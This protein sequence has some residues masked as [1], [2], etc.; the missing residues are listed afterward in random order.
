M[1]LHKMFRSTMTV[2]LM[3]LLSRITGLVRDIA[4]AQFLGSGLVADAFFVAFRIP[5]FFR[6]IF[7][8]GA[9]SAGFVPVYAEYESQYPAPEVRAFLD[10]MLGRL[11]LILLLFTLLGVLGAPWLV[12]IIAPGFVEHPDK[13]AATVEALRFTFPYLFFV[14][15]VAMAGGILNTRG[16]FAVPAITPVFL[17]LFLIGAV[18]WAVP[19]ATHKALTLGIGVF[20][21]GVVQLGFQLPFLAFE[22]RLPFP[23]I[24]TGKGTQAVAADGVGRVFS[25]MLP[26]LFGVSVAQI[27][28]LINTVLASFLVTGSV[29]WLYYSDRLMEFPVGVFGIALA[30]VILPKLSKQVAENAVEEYRQTIDWALRLALLVVCPAAV[31]LVVLAHPLMLT[32]FQYGEFTDEDARMAARSLVAFSPGLIG[33][34]LVKVLAPGFF[35]RKDTKTPVRA[36]VIAMAVNGLCA[37]AL[38]LAVPL[39]H[40]GLAA[41]TSI[42]GLVNAGLLYRYLVRDSG[43]MSGPGMSGFAV[44][45]AAAA[46]VMGV[47][48]WFG[49]PDRQFWVAASVAGRLWQL[50]MWVPAGTVV[51]FVCLYVV[52]LKPHR[53]FQR[54]T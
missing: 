10:L 8:E 41:A 26:A 53:L 27:N 39:G 43:Y 24:M 23:K 22:R 19:F 29:S 17:N 36:G 15:L 16:R 49:V 28:L 54:Q 33:F 18:I 9:F 5:N 40:V 48:L 1:V 45:T 20:V 51:Y 37:A 46:I 14:S 4:F 11:A 42:S 7:A 44:K 35:A 38:T 2:S 21:A 12:T 47:V 31:A 3:T 32:L 34:V 6:R 30:T 50:V 52:G 25:L 13:Y